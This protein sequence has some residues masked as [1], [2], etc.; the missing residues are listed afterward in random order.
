MSILFVLGLILVGCFV[1]DVQRDKK[2][3]VRIVKPL[4]VFNNWK[5]SKDQ[6]KIS[7]VSPGENLKVARIRYGKDYMAIKVERED[8]SNG[9]LIYQRGSIELVE[10]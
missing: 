9:W 2:K 5:R 6:Q 3:S 1:F 4:P 7:D 8:R 10:R